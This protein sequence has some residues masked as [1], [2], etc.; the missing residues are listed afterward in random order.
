MSLVNDALRRAKDAQQPA[1]LPP[2]PDLPFQPVEPARQCARRGRGRLPLV[3]LAVVALLTLLLAWQWLHKRDSTGSA[4]GNA[5]TALVARAIPAPP[6]ASI[7]APAQAAQ[8]G[9]TAQPASPAP[10]VAGAPAPLAADATSAATNTP[11]ADA[12]AEGTNAAA[13]T[14][15]QP[16][17][18][19]LQ[20]IVFDP[21]RPSAMISGKTL[22]VGD[23]LGDLRVVAIDKESVTLVGAG[24]TN[25]LSLSE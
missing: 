18:L 10:S 20:A 11:V 21:R 22:F 15:P 12:Q 3:T 6:S 2:S 8:P 19:R 23:K 25:V 14:P 16:A 5:R 4:E 24:Q 17:P 13:M 1:P 7:A 9:S